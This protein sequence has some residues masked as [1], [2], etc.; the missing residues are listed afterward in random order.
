MDILL[1]DDNASVRK[2]LREKL[3]E[4]QFLKNA[5]YRIREYSSGEELINESYMGT[6]ILFL[7]IEMEGINGIET[8][9]QI[10]KVNS[11]IIIIF[12]T[13][14]KEYVFEG[15]KVNAFRYL[16]KPIDVNELIETMDSI[17]KMLKKEDNILIL[18]F[19]KEE[20]CIKMNEIMFIEIQGRKIC[21]HCE[22]NKYRSVGSLEALD[23]KLS[24]NNFFRVHK[25][26]VVNL[27]QI[28]KFDNQNVYFKNDETVPISRLR[29]QEF[30][31]AY[32]DYW[33]ENYK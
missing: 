22:L 21:V 8:A 30:K 33:K 23:E 19:G 2:F 28:K 26:F 14:Y 17:E 18:S 15:Y 31:K 1:C 27:E 9:K 32:L 12:L 29:L 25:S 5:D 6:A 16:L 13:A 10:R 4:Y 24:T 7:D 20:Y 3:L 11:N